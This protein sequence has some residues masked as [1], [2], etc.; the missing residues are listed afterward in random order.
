MIEVL[1]ALALSAAVLSAT[2]SLLFTGAKA[3]KRMH[4]RAELAQTGRVV[5]E[6]IESD[7]RGAMPL[8]QGKLQNAFVVKGDA[9][10]L[11]FTTLMSI[12]DPN[13]TQAPFDRPAVGIVKYVWSAPPA[14]SVAGGASLER[15]WSLLVPD[16]APAYPVNGQDAFPPYLAKL[17]FSYAYQNAPGGYPPVVW[18][19]QWYQADRI[20]G[21]VRVDL[22]LKRP[23]ASEEVS[24]SKTI[25]VM[26]GKLGDAAWIK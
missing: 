4:E 15:D 9:S 14:A 1:L 11:S 21:G 17:A 13:A 10:S 8:T 24:L 3:W 18:Q 23:G 12:A 25:D 5:L 7:L 2:Y 6:R 26:Q 16:G 19:S 22:V 20:P